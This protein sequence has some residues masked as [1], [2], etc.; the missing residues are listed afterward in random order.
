MLYE[1]EMFSAVHWNMDLKKYMCIALPLNNAL[2]TP[3][4]SA[5]H[6]VFLDFWIHH[7]IDLCCFPSSAEPSGSGRQRWVWSCWQKPRTWPQCNASCSPTPTGP[8]FTHRRH[9]LSPASLTAPQRPTTHPRTGLRP[10]WG[11]RWVMSEIQLLLVWLVLLSVGV[12]WAVRMLKLCFRFLPS[13]WW[14]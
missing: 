7:Y 1:A 14:V 4:P 13:L 3:I 11:P 2:G 6:P 9:Q 5:L 12:C 8:P 10:L